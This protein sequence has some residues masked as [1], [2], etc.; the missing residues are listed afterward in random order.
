ME[1]DAIPVVN[2]LSSF[3]RFDLLRPT[4]L[5]SGNI[6]RAGTAGIIYDVVK[7]ARVVFQYQRLRTDETANRFLIGWQLNF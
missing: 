3:G 2:H 7:Y 6:V 5:V 1:V 4:T